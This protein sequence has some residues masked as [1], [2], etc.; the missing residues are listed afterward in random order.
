MNEELVVKIL[1]IL[2]SGTDAEKDT[3]RK[4]YPEIHRTY[5]P[6]VRDNAEAAKNYFWEM[7]GENFESSSTII[8]GPFHFNGKVYEYRTTIQESKLY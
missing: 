2:Q 4:L 5:I 3:I 7:M 8:T 6:T 1:N